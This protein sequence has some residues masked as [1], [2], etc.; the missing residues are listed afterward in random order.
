MQAKHPKK[1]LKT[2]VDDRVITPSFTIVGRIQTSSIKANA[3]LFGQ[4]DLPV[5]RMRML[6]SLGGGRDVEVAV[7]ASRYGNQG[8]WLD[9]EYVVDGLNAI[10]ITASGTVDV[11]PQQGGNY[12]VGPGG[13]Q[14]R[15]M[16]IAFN[17][18]M[19]RGGAKLRNPI[20]GQIHGGALI[21]KI[22]EDG[23]MFL[24][25]ERYEGTPEQQGKLYL[26]VGPSPWNNQQ[27][28]SYDVKIARKN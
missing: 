24:I 15:N 17:A 20:N 6:R 2:S 13:L 22:G 19:M 8:Q 10:T 14:G 21:G 11:W 27:S 25:G 5:A 16:G 18:A 28:G 4:V 7:D 9:T 1:D 3:E 26:H 23:E 12:I